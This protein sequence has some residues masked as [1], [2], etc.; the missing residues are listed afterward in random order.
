MND[1]RNRIHLLDFLKGISI[2]SVVLYHAGVLKYGYLG[3]DVFFV[4]AGYLSMRGVIAHLDCPFSAHQF[5]L[6]KLLRLLPLILLSA[7]V[8]MFIGGLC[9]IP[10]VFKGILAWV[11]ASCLFFQNFKLGFDS[12]SYWAAGNELN[13]FLHLW[14]VAALVQVFVVFALCMWG[15]NRINVKRRALVLGFLGC[16]SFCLFAFQ[17]PSV[18]A[19]YYMPTSRFWEFALGCILAY[20]GFRPFSTP[21]IPL[22]CDLGICSYSIY[23]WHQ[24]I[25]AYYRMTICYAKW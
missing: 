3:V 17:F 7:I 19:S 12:V 10:F 24:V 4:I 21:R 23:I 9:C 6:G 22:I 15:V 16:V 14:Y 13:P 5:L 8:V 18:Q 1:N 11:I 2:I 25:L 20:C